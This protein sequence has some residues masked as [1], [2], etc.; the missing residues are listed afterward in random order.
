MFKSKCKNI[1]YRATLCVCLLM[2]AGLAQSA[3]TK[4]ND[5]HWSGVDRVIAISDL[6]GDYQQ[7][8]K[9]MQSAGLINAKGK[10]IGGKTHLVQT[11]DITDR[12]P[13]SRKIIDHLIKLSKQANKKGGHIHMLI[14]NHEAMNVSGDLRYVH[15]EEYAVFANSKSLHLQELQWQRQLEMVQSLDAKA[16]AALDLAAA[17]SKWEK[18]IPLGWVEHR[19]AWA[20]DGEYGKWVLKNPVAIRINDTVYLHGGISS[21]FCR[22]SLRSLS[23]LMH[24]GL[25]D[26]DADKP[27]IVDDPLGPTWYR[28][29]AQE[30]ESGVYSQ[31]L[32]NVLKRYKVKRMVVGHTPTDGIVWPR[33]DQRVIVNDTGI[34]KYYGANKGILELQGG[35]ATAIYAGQRIQIPQASSERVDYLRAVI[36]VNPDNAKLKKRLEKLLASEL[37]E[38]TS[39]EE[40][41]TEEP[42]E[43]AVIGICQ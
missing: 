3:A 18:K 17:R 38:K 4:L 43:A 41:S 23:K 13:D 8:F 5:Y 42:E 21:K 16:F 1:L 31:T 29:L 9:V 33:F 37:V 39:A 22:Y 20:V 12:G 32:D 30:D 15:A 10:W 19:A 36:K 40:A 7:Y 14:G 34:A 11:G 28:G 26:Y 27:S 2:L 6:H 35:V 25:S 24:E